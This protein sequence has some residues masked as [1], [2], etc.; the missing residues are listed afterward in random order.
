M[1][2]IVISG[3]VWSSNTSRFSIDP[4]DRSDSYVTVE[5]WMK[6]YN[7][8]SGIWFLFDCRD[9]VCMFV[10]V[11][12]SDLD[13]GIMDKFKDSCSNGLCIKVPI[14]LDI[15][16]FIFREFLVYCCRRFWNNSN[17]RWINGW[18]VDLLIWGN[19]NPIS[20]CSIVSNVVV[21]SCILVYIHCILMFVL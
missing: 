18:S 14:F 15:H 19:K 3:A 8:C 17:C 7:V 21:G 1:K 11:G 4:S 5:S 9:I 12:N 13:D 10:V 6:C 2:M 20:L 16:Q